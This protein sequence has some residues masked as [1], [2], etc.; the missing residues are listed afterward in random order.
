MKT[1]LTLLIA[2]LSLNAVWAQDFTAG[3]I[4][5][6]ITSGTT[7]EVAKNDV[8]ISGDITVPEKVTDPNS[9]IEYTVTALAEEAFRQC[10]L[11]TNITLPASIT[12]I[13]D[14]AFYLCEILE[15]VNIPD[16]ITEIGPHTFYKCYQLT[17]VTFPSS[18]TAI[19]E[20]AFDQ[21]YLLESVNIPDGVTEI[22]NKMFYKCYA[23]KSITIPDSVT[24]IADEAFYQC[25][26]L[27]SI[28][29]PDSVASI[30]E[31]AFQECVLATAINIPDGITTIGY[32]TFYKCYVLKSITIPDSVTAIG[33]EAFLQSE[34]LTD[35]I[36]KAADPTTI[37]LG[38]TIFSTATTDTATL[39]VPNGSLTAYS[40]A[41]QWADFVNMQEDSTLSSPN[42][43]SIASFSVYP[44]P[45]NGT[46]TLDLAGITPTNIQVYD[47]HGRSV[48]TLPN[49]SKQILNLNITSGI[50]ILN[51]E[52]TQGVKQL[53]IVVE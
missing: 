28:T 20:N 40:T 44:N 45:S 32:R 6:N 25:K 49:Y 15:T 1:K 2:F 35:V 41:S 39:T 29:I 36:V 21:C 8:T 14:K 27:E 10:N 46:F 19:G 30:G 43:L 48:K 52:S 37:T 17:G 51:I 53:K 7:V 47:M 22:G 5:Y 4:N 33:D 11:V 18:V 9:S 13:G 12:A 24:A 26:A 16:G 50:Y 42:D 31:K 23:L 34:D 38:A 3:S